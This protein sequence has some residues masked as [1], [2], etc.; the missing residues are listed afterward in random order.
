[1]S[2][3]RCQELAD[4]GKAPVFNAKHLLD[5]LAYVTALCFSESIPI[6]R[7]NVKYSACA[8]HG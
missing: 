6:F 3:G 7:N 4:G 5:K 8:E 1:M 2:D